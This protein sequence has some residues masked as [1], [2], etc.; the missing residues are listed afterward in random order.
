M[1]LFHCSEK[2]KSDSVCS[3]NGPFSNF[4]VFTFFRIL[5]KNIYSILMIII[6]YNISRRV[7]VC[8]LV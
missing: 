4:T 2:L 3:Q 6:A 1:R 7:T 5:F 8:F